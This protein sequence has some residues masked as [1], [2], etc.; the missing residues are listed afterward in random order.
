MGFNKKF[1]GKDDIERL[2]EDLMSIKI[3]LNSD[4]LIFSNSEISEKFKEYEKKYNSNR[5]IT[6]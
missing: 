3:Y 4:C 6:R 5:I 2:E 1:V